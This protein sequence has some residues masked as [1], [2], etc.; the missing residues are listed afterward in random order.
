MFVKS[1]CSILNLDVIWKLLLAISGYTRCLFYAGTG[2]IT[3]IFTCSSLHFNCFL[4]SFNICSKISNV[5][6]ASAMIPFIFLKILVPMY[7]YSFKNGIYNREGH[8]SN[9]YTR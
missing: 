5:L 4:F 2:L 8:H 3:V 6:F 1:D 7:A 9:S